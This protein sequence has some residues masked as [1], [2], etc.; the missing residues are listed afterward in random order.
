[1]IHYV[2][3]NRAINGNTTNYVADVVSQPGGGGGGRRAC[4]G[5]S[6]GDGGDGEAGW[7][8]LRDT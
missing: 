5:K 8:A 6:G 3:R 4:G 1:M 7:A 2:I